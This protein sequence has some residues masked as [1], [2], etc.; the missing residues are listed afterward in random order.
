METP[1]C[2]L[3]NSTWLLLHTSIKKY[4]NI[5]FFN[6]LPILYLDSIKRT[7]NPSHPS[8][9]TTGYLTLPHPNCRQIG[10]AIWMHII[11][12][13]HICEDSPLLHTC[14][15]VYSLPVAYQ[16]TFIFHMWPPYLS[17]CRVCGIAKRALRGSWRYVTLYTYFRHH[18]GSY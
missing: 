13:L 7:I 14:N 2:A 12:P 16:Y 10:I 9:K 1:Y 18:F 15:V 4:H 17:I 8:Q 11:C 5:L 6:K 3:I